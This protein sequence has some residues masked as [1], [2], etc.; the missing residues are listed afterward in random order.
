MFKISTRFNI[1]VLNAWYP[2]NVSW[3][4]L[5]SHKCHWDENSQVKKKYT[6]DFIKFQFLK[7]M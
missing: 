4:I 1:L 6:I 5:E 7:L 3:N 2:L